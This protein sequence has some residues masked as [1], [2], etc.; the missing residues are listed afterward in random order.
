MLSTTVIIGVENIVLRKSRLNED[1]QI[2]HP[3]GTIN[4]GIKYK[5]LFIA[6]TLLII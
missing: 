6:Y 5:L 2:L 3:L 1:K 4:K